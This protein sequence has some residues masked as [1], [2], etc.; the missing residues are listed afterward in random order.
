M[1]FPVIPE[2]NRVFG[3]YSYLYTYR[4]C[5]LVC[6]FLAKKLGNQ[7]KTEVD[8]SSKA[9]ACGDIAVHDYVVLQAYCI[10]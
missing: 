1:V 10:S 9:A 4:F 6:F 8:G 7:G 5:D 2:K 3:G